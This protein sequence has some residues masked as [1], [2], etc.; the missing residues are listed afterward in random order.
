MVFLTTP[1]EGTA[2]RRR[3]NQK[4][5]GKTTKHRASS[6]A[7]SLGRKDSDN[8]IPIALELATHRSAVPVLILHAIPHTPV[9]CRQDTLDRSKCLD[10]SRRLVGDTADI[11]LALYAPYSGEATG[12]CERHEYWKPALPQNVGHHVVGDCGQY[13][14]VT[15]R[16]IVRTGFSHVAPAT[17][18]VVL[19]VRLPIFVP[20]WTLNSYAITGFIW[21]RSRPIVAVFSGCPGSG[22]AQR[23][24]RCSASA[25]L[26]CLAA[27]C[28]SASTTLIKIPDHK[29]RHIF[30]PLHT[31]NDC[32]D[33][34]SSDARG[35]DAS[36]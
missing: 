32:H 24:A 29:I 28:L 21:Y 23:M 20:F 30:P 35:C 13:A 5:K 26:P 36:R 12:R 14:R 31:M 19:T 1:H 33:S 18:T 17:D 25:L 3:L 27:R 9:L 8:R 7:A 22:C 16:L 34:I 15:R 11:G 6:A 2:T 4:A 10:R